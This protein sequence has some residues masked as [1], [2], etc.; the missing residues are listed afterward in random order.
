VPIY[1]DRR[2]QAHY[3]I[4]PIGLLRFRYASLGGT[5]SAS[6]TDLAS[7]GSTGH[8]RIMGSVSPNNGFWVRISTKALI[9]LRPMQNE[10]ICRTNQHSMAGKE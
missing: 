9:S 10:P 1:Y 8:C 4:F 3:M 7:T 5:G 2:L 6:L